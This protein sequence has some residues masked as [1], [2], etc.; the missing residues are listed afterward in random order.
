MAVAAS[1][2]RV[3][4]IVSSDEGRPVHAGELQALIRMDQYRLLRFAP[5]YHHVQRL[6]NHFGGL[7]AL[8]RP[9]HHA[10]GVEV[11]QDSQK[12]KA[13][14]GVD[15]GNVCHPGCGSAWKKISW[16]RAGA[17]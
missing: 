4:K 3:L 8:H 16:A 9:T 7:P 6:Q 17:G 2:H 14:Q 12:G 5:P 11:D 15:V 13:L 10:L 1:A